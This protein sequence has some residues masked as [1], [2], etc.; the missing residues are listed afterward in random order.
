VKGSVLTGVRCR[1][2]EAEGCVLINVTADHIIAAPGSVI[3][4][5]VADS[6]NACLTVGPG[7]VLAGVFNSDGSQHIVKSE[8][9]IDGGK[10]W[11]QVLS[12]MGNTHSFEQVYN[13]NADSNPLV[14]ESIISGTHS[15]AWEKLSLTPTTTPRKTAAGFAKTDAEEKRQKC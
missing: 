13:N 11:E 1:H 2:I 15:L 7:Q 14:L 5:I 4:N 9:G 10:A 8:M 12:D 3:Y 6:N